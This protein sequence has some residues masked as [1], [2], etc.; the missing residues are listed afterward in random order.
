MHNYG[1]ANLYLYIFKQEPT[2]TKK[3]YPDVGQ[4]GMLGFHLQNE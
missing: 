4:V 3:N 2:K 1:D